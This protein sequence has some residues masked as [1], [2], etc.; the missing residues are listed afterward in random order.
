MLL[1]I[2]FV[3]W[4]PSCVSHPDSTPASNVPGARIT[5]E[6]SPAEVEAV[7]DY[8]L[9]REREPIRLKL[10]NGEFF[11]V[12]LAARTPIAHGEIVTIYPGETVFIEAT[13][14]NGQLTNLTGVRQP[15]HPERTITFRFSQ[16]PEM[17]DGTHMLLKVESPFPQPLKYRLGMMRPTSD[18]LFN[19][20]SCPVHAGHPVF[21]HWSHPIFQLVAIDFRLVS[22][23]SREA[24]V[25]E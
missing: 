15:T 10:A 9:C 3:V 17:A 24:R 7:C 5:R 11:E 14:E 21:E 20:S 13:P 18:D 23:S 25:C 22:E 19:T 4:W 12:T 8:V 16:D 2:G 6:A 1:L